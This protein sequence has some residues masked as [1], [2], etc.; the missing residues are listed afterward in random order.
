MVVPGVVRPDGSPANPVAPRSSRPAPL[1]STRAALANRSIELAKLDVQYLR[2]DLRNVAFI[3]GLMLA[4]IIA[5]SFVL[6]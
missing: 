5:L 1:S 6:H 3:A 2:H 4:I